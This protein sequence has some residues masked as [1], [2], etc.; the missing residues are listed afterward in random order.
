MDRRHEESL[1]YFLVGI[2]NNCFLRNLNIVIGI[3][4][5][6]FFYREF[7]LNV[8]HR[9]FQ[10]NVFFH[11]DIHSSQNFHSDSSYDFYIILIF[12]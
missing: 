2:P 11:R 3:F 5:Q 7:Q 4:S 10:S 1:L 9:D 8:V 12:I 6:M